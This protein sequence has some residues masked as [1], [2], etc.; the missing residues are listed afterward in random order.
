MKKT[1]LGVA[2][3]RKDLQARQQIAETELAPLLQDVKRNRD[4]L[5]AELLTLRF[6]WHQ[7]GHP[8]PGKLWDVGYGSKGYWCEAGHFFGKM[9]LP[10]NKESTLYD[11]RIYLVGGDSN[12]CKCFTEHCREAEAIFGRMA[13]DGTRFNWTNMLFETFRDAVDEEDR[14]AVEWREN[15]EPDSPET[16]S[17]IA[18]FKDVFEWTRILLKTFM[19]GAELRQ[20]SPDGR[21]PGDE[22]NPTTVPTAEIPSGELSDSVAAVRAV[23]EWAISTIPGADGMTISELFD[24]IQLHPKM[25]SEYL[26]RLPDNPD[27][28]GTYLRRA[29]IRR[30]DKSGSRARRQ[31]R[32]RR[33]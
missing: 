31:S 20:R 12:V 8:H 15:E 33:T 17:Y 10:I 2:T 27:T 18:E 13:G 1:G 30:Y 21:L 29:G 25:P 6:V 32:R 7:A 23:Y 3:R 26:E 9:E 4:R 28:F 5:V 24:A 11:C 22:G 14:A 16:W 19:D